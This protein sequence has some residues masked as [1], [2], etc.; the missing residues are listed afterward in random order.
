[1]TMDDI[2]SQPLAPVRDDGF[3]AQVVLKLRRAEEKRR[4][5]LW[6]AMALALLP[7]LSVLPL[8]STAAIGAAILAKA[9]NSPVFASAVGLAVLLWSLRPQRSRF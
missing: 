6:G 3:S 8:A 2:L 9:G 5:L 1:M 7:L 4:L